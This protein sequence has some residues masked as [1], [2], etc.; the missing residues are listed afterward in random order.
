MAQTNRGGISGTVFDGTGA[1]V[2][3]ASVTITNLGTNQKIKDKTSPNGTYSVGSLDPVTY[4]VA[5]EVAGFK[6]TL[7]DLVKVDTATVTTVNATLETGPVATEV[8]MQ[9]EATAINP[10][11]HT[12]TSTVN[13]RQPHDTPRG[14][15]GRDRAFPDSI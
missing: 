8:T 15:A 12:T 11:S 9:G 13:T 1:V 4:S 10:E 5:V 7:I 14:A 2:P 3:N 6:K